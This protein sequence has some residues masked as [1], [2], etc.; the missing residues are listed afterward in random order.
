M[1]ACIITVGNEILK[2]RTVNTNAAE[3]GRILY[4]AG[5]EIYRGIT[6][7][8]KKEEIGL[9]FRSCL[10]VCD[11]VVSSGGLGPT[12]DD[13]TIPSFALEFKLPLVRD[14]K[15]YDKIQKRFERRGLTMTEERS[16]MAMIPDTSSTVE[17]SIG[18]APGV[19]VQIN[20]KRVYILPGVPR[21]MRPMMESILPEIKLDDSYYTEDSITVTGIPES[22]LAPL[23]VELMKKYGGEIY[24]KTHPSLTEEGLSIIEVEISTRSR[25]PESG[26]DSVKKALSE[27]E[28][29]AEEI[30]S[31][32]REND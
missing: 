2:G 29:R 12:F 3:I 31:Q 14:D 27:F 20:G 30:R 23:S 22:V 4:F 9:A 8:D 28:T 26:I 25:D 17:N 11:V 32:L 1:R 10:D 7:P 21:E 18:S 15:T 19:R 24:I 16:K 6:V 5:Y 13:I